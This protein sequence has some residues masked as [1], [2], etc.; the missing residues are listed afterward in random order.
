MPHLLHVWSNVSQRL[1]HASQVLLLF[2]YDGT[3]TPLM[4]DPEQAI[5][6]PQVRN[7]LTALV[8][9]GKYIAGVISGRSLEDVA[10]KVGIPG[11]I[12]AGNHGLEIKGPGLDFVHQEAVAQAGTQVQVGVELRRALAGMPGVIVEPKGLT[13][14]VHYRSTPVNQ[15]KAVEEAF[16]QVVAPYVESGTARITHGK[17]VLEVRPNLP[18]DKGKAIAMLQQ[19]YPQASLTCFFGDDQTDED[20]FGVVQE[21]GGIAVLVGPARQ[22]TIA[23]HRVDSP[24]EVAQVLALLAQI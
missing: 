2:D 16:A 12:Y 22:P 6:P 1:L 23:W 15:V 11:M 18:W 24:G 3:L 4:P 17:K 13:L 8:S 14:S 9:G 19:T 7:L 20:G 21:S 10:A 5:L